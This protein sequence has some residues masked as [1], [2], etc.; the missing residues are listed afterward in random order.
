MGTNKNAETLEQVQERHA[1]M[2]ATA[3]DIGLQ[4]P[5]ELKTDFT[6]AVAGQAIASNLDALI[7]EYQSKTTTDKGL[8]EDDA[9]EHN[10]ASPPKVAKK[11]SNKPKKTAVKKTAATSGSN[12]AE[13]KQVAKATKKTA[14]KKTA[15]KS[16]SDNARKGVDRYA[17]EAKITKT[18]KDNP[19]REG[20]GKYD[21]IANVL[22]HNGKTVK[23]Y[24]ASGGKGG[25][26]GWCV[27]NGLVKVA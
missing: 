27:K 13:E 14:A 4:V 16:A 20:S 21:R 17:D 19:A 1:E 11:A 24:K 15:K 7:R 3:A 18:G 26:L 2:L 8:A 25:T 9:R 6:D 22:K 10:D 23:T 5:E 12:K